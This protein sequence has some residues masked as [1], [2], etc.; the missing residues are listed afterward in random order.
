MVEKE[1]EKIHSLG[2]SFIIFTCFLSIFIGKG[3]YVMFSL[4]S[5]D[6][7][8]CSIFGFLASFV[9]MAIISYIINYYTLGSV[10]YHKQNGLFFIV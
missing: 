3:T 10:Q 5:N 9:L 6:T 8:I 1:S 4:T 2:Y 7:L